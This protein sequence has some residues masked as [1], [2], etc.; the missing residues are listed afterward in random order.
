MRR[1]AHR[2][3]QAYT[4]ALDKFQF[5]SGIARLR[6]FTNTIGSFKAASTDEKWALR[7]ALTLMTQM[8]APLMPHLGEEL[9]AMLGYKELLVLSAWPQADAALAKKDSVTI[10][11]QVNG[12]MRAT[13]TLPMG[14]DAA[15]AESTALAHENVVPWVTGKSIKKIV[16]VP[17]RIVNVVVA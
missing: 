12:K 2:A 8:L 17:D 13:I 10:A 4:E 16:V 9:W 5:N 11:V 7:E 15:L 6:E 14:C 3:L 1:T